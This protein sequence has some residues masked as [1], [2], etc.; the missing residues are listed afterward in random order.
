MNKI[1]KSSSISGSVWVP[2]SKS[3]THRALILAA[4]ADGMTIIR[5]PLTAED[6]EATEKVL[7]KLGT[8]I[9]KKE[10]EWRVNGSKLSHSITPLNC[11]ESG[12]TLRI[13]TAVASLVKGK[14]KLIGGPSL[15]NRP[16]GALVD[17]LRMIGIDAKSNDGYPPTIIQGTGQIKGGKT[18]LPGNISSQFVSAILIISPLATNPVTIEVSTPL[19]SKPYV[20]MTLDAMKEFGVQCKA[21][22]DLRLFQIPLMNYIPTQIT[23]EGDWSSAAYMLAA[24]V[25][26]GNLIIHGLN[27]QSGQSDQLILDILNKMGAN[28]R[29][30]KEGIEVSK[31]ILNCI[32]YDLSDCPDLFPIVSVLCS[33]ARGVSKLTG[34]ERLRLKESDRLQAM[35]DGLLQMGVDV[36]TD[37]NTCLI[38]GGKTK[39]TEINTYNDHRIAM[40]FSI[41]SLISEGETIIQYSESVSKSYPLFWE[42]FLNIGANIVGDNI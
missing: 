39:G 3:M 13:M 10:N 5:N 26:A 1:L 29:I 11:G 23:I 28:L 36:K 7:G 12:T 21:S 35:V 18:S 4:I 24:G 42:D 33:S 19:E 38:R 40:A 37:S 15:S 32:E 34:L 25:L 9:Q 31:S 17:A 22:S 6:T 27:T 14:T 2:S 41:L 16:V 30:K 20:S 8:T